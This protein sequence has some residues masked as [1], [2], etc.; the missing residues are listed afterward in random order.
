MLK[1]IIN[2]LLNR[3]AI[4]YHVGTISLAGFAFMAPM[5]VPIPDDPTNQAGLHAAL[6]ALCMGGLI[7]AE[8]ASWGG[9]SIQRIRRPAIALCA[10]CSSYLWLVEEN[11]SD[12]TRFELPVMIL[13][14]WS[15]ALAVIVLPFIFLFT[16]M[17]R[18]SNDNC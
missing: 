18:R 4:L 9:S 8:T 16:K 13:V 14:V 11:G 10:I 5:L 2:D 6:V 15:M 12:P 3:L 1:R 7:F 17:P